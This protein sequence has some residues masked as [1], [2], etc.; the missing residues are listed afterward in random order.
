LC[1]VGGLGHCD[2]SLAPGKVSGESGYG[3]E[4]EEI[5]EGDFAAEVLLEP[6]L[7]FSNREGVCAEIEEVLVQVDVGNTEGLAPGPGYDA[8]HF[9]SAFADG[10]RSLE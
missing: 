4:L 9:G 2:Y 6:R 3:G 8:L 1:A 5:N 10:F 7:D